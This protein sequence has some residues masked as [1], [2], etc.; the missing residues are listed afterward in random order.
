MPEDLAI[1]FGHEAAEAHAVLVQPDVQSP[2]LAGKDR[3]R[4]SAAELFQTL[5]A[6]L[7][8][9]C[10]KQIGRD[11]IGGK[12]VQDRPVK[13]GTRRD[14]ARR[15]ADCNRPKDERSARPA[16]AQ[17]AQ[18]KRIEDAIPRFIPNADVREPP[19]SQPR[20]GNRHS[21]SLES[22][23]PFLRQ[24]PLPAIKARRPH[25]ALRTRPSR[26]REPDQNLTLA[27]TP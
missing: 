15:E 11:S 9:L 25:P 8:K 3:S 5:R 13:P 6:S 22:R 18:A 23:A 17:Q 21:L 27:V 4:E 14:R 16:Q 7:S 24:P 10:H 19:C 26:S 20:L 2:I 12:T 1:P